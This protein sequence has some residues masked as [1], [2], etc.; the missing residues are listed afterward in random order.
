MSRHVLKTLFMIVGAMLGAWFVHLSVLDPAQ[1]ATG[2][3]TTPTNLSG[4]GAAS[5]PIIAAGPDGT[6]HAL[7]WDAV[8]GEQYA[9]TNVVSDTWNRPIT[10]RSILGQRIVTTD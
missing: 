5:Q 10:L 3:W 9:Y 8:A 4:S 7:W 1:T 6:L 2:P